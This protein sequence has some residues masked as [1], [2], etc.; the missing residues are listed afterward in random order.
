MRTRHLYASAI[1]VFI[2]I[3]SLGAQLP[4]LSRDGQ[5]ADTLSRGGRVVSGPEE[6][7]LFRGT[8]NLATLIGYGLAAVASGLA[9]RQW[10]AE[11]RWKR[12][13]VL[14]DRIRAFGDTP[15]A[16]NAMMMLTSH[17]R[18][19]PLW[20]KERPE[21]RYV[22][23]TW[24]EVKRALIPGDLIAY[25]HD[26][27]ENAI[28]DSFEDFLG[29]LAHIEVYLEA[30]LLNREDASHIVGTWIARFRQLSADPQLLRNLRLYIDWRGMRSTQKLFKRFDV[31]LTQNLPVLR[32]ELK[33]EV[34][35]GD[36]AAAGCN[37][38]SGE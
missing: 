2:T 38:V 3:R 30:G 20:D 1:A 24:G 19:V 32:D 15:G 21:E 4:T 6:P 14:M 31:D 36:W 22:R 28:R 29:R 35:R 10:K 13:E 37:L 8:D 5:R 33:V 34:D 17:D 12:K 27:K 11:Q 25:T 7:W 18:E 9:F 16:R 26:A 23:V